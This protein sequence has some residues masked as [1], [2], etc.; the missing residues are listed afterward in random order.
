M[1]DILI[2]FIV[3]S[4]NQKEHIQNKL[5]PSIYKAMKDLK[6]EILIMDDGSSDINPFS[7]S[8]FNNVKLFTY[9][10]SKNQSMLRNIGIKKSIGN[11]IYFID[12]DDEFIEF[13]KNNKKEKNI[14]LSFFY[15][16][17]KLPNVIFLNSHQF[18]NNKYEDI[19]HSLDEPLFGPE[20]AIYKKEFLIKNNIFLILKIYIFIV[21]YYLNF[22]K[23]K[24]MFSI[25]YI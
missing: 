3:L 21:F 17:K 12:G 14:F 8:E 1:K 9:K 15:N 19:I 6:F 22:L 11:W 24:I 5:I 20:T 2:S 4:Y 10:H 23:L 13:N 7:Y 18:I 16:Y 25:I